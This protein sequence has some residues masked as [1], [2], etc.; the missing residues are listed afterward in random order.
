MLHY[1]PLTATLDRL[2]IM[3]GGRESC[4][5]VPVAYHVRR[6]R[7]LESLSQDDLAERAHVDRATVMR[8][9]QLQPV[10]LSTLRKLARALR[11]HPRELMQST[12]DRQQE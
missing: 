8:A 6:L 1:I 3:N 10:R 11:V 7:L 12:V 5:A 9:E 2:V 4:P